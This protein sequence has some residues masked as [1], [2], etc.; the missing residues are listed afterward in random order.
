M[1]SSVTPYCHRSTLFSN[2]G[3]A[4][5]GLFHLYNGLPTMTIYGLVFIDFYRLN[6]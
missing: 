3:T 5:R 4:R 1:I 2:N 6:H